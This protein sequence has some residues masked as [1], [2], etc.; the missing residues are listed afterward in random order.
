MR[1]SRSLVV[2]YR[3]LTAQGPILSKHLPTC[4]VEGLSRPKTAPPLVSPEQQGTLEPLQTLPTL[5]MRLDRAL[6]AGWKESA[7]AASCRA[8]A[9]R[10]AASAG[11]LTAIR[12]A[13]SA[14]VSAGRSAAPGRGR[15]CGTKVSDCLRWKKG[16]HGGGMGWESEW[17]WCETNVVFA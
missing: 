4:P 8:A 10:A 15:V 16:V 6:I 3:R 1:S 9:R 17:C 11:S 5:P 12:R 2:A 13:R 7:A 14:G